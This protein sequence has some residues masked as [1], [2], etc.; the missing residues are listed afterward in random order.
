MKWALLCL[1]VSGSAFGWESTCYVYADPTLEVAAYTGLVAPYC[2]SAGP[3]AARNRWVGGLDEHRGLWEQARALAG[4]PATVSA[5]LRLQVFTSS[6][7][8]QVG[9]RTL[10]SLRPVP[11]DQATRAQL[12]A[13]SVGEME[14]FRTGATRCGTGQTATRPARWWER[15]TPASCATTSPRT[16]GR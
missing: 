8:L 4:L 3:L 12:R 9:S 7:P 6:T 13:Y 1:W 16:W 11:F 10:T 14:R 2:P 15:T 5:T